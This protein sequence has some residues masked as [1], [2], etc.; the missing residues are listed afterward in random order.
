[1]SSCFLRCQRHRVPRR[2]REGQALA[3]FALVLPVLM[4]ILLSIVQLGF[5][6]G[7]QIGLINAVRETARFGSLAPTT[8]TNAGANS[9]SVDNLPEDVEP[10][11]ERPGL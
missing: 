3:E 1:M 9:T 8:E 2:T 4:L 10:A 5:M 11:P 7:G 6:L